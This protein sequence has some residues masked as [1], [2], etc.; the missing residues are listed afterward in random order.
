[1]HASKNKTQTQSLN[2]RIRRSLIYVFVAIIITT[3]AA[4]LLKKYVLEIYSVPSS[5][6][7]P[8]L[9]P[10]DSVI[11]LKMGYSQV[12]SGDVIVFPHPKTGELFIKRVVSE[13]PSE[14]MVIGRKVWV[15]GVQEEISEYDNNGSNEFIS[16]SN[17]Y[18][19]MFTKI[20]QSWPKS[21]LWMV[22]ADN[23]FVLGDYR[24]ESSD[25]RTWGFV[26]KNEITGV[27]ICIFRISDFSCDI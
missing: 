13:G 8:S 12:K 25:S 27:A 23:Y 4:V 14:V 26:D 11:V 20:D 24:D 19:V 21:G 10:G 18:N 17:N 9:Y 6:M 2:T 7:Q 22:P 15:D 3:P 16:K 5:S 1:M